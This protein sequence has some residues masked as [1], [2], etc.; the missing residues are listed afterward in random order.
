VTASS[1]THTGIGGLRSLL[2]AMPGPLWA[3]IYVGIAA[4]TLPA[5]LPVMVGVLADQLGFG[6]VHAGYAASV[7]MGGA[8][9]GS[10]VGA[11]LTRRWSWAS[12]IIVGAAVM[13]GCNV[14][15]MLG[16]SFPYV[17]AMRLASGLGEGMISGICYAAMGRSGQPARALA[18]YAAG[19]GLVGAAGMGF[20]TTVVQFAGWQI[21]FV[22]VSV[23]A[24]PAFWLARRI[25]T[26]E[27]RDL[28]VATTAKS[29]PLTWLGWGAVGALL[30]QFIG[31]SSIWAF[32]ERLGHAKGIDP[33]HLSIAMSATAIASMSGSLAV[34][35]FAHRVRGLQG[36]A[37]AF[38]VFIVSIAGLL[39]WNDWQVYLIAGVLFML[40]WSVYFPFQFGLLAEFDS[41]G[42]LAAI[43]P[44]V[45]GA[46]FTVGPALG[47][48]LMAKGGI[49]GIL[50]WGSACLGISTLACVGL[51]RIS[52]R[53]RH[54]MAG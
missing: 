45:T 39:L 48:L 23:L 11:V 35:I 29:V 38:I 41:G 52:R 9:L 8:A 14:L 4:A 44:A 6:L 27:V 5:V 28:P 46:A 30:A 42:R 50:A 22:L 2:I 21:L 43:M 7:N 16:T 1:R 17:A 25:G 51:Y 37:G 26:L 33:F 24:V 40:A 20:M 47:G 31:M 3:A 10:V 18:F 53:D 34:G 13:I 54:D 19:Q 32:L 36:I 12:V 49:G 15:T